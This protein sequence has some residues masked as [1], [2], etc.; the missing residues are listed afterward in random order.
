MLAPKLRF[1]GFKGE[2][3]VVKL[4]DIAHFSKGA[5]V[6]KSDIDLSGSREA[7]RYGEL[8]TIYGEVVGDVHSKIIPSERDVLSED[9]DVLIPSSGETAID[10]STA[11]YVGKNGVAV[12]GD[13][14]IIRTNESGRFLSY[15]LNHGKKLDVARLAQGVSVV[16]LYASELKGLQIEVPAK[17]E[18]EKI[19]DFLMAVDERIELQS[20]KVE[21]LKTYKRG[22]IQKIFSRQ[23]RF[24]QPNGTTF[25][26][27]EIV[28]LGGVA[29]V[30]KGVQLNRDSME[31]KGFPVING[32]VEPSGYTSSYN[33]EK[34]N[35][36]V[37]EGG[38]SCGFVNYIKERFWS[39]GHCYVVCENEHI[40]KMFLFHI[41]KYRQLDIMKLR[42]GSGLPNIQKKDFENMRLNIPVSAEEQQ[43]IATLLSQIDEKITLE[44]KKLEGLKKFKKSLLQRMF[45]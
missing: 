9:N 22:L 7:I 15:L 5:G 6:S 1:P 14:N 31:Q 24:I 39:G 45:V 41:L 38:N 33:T 12:G 32:G 40:N 21:K 19:A 43:K 10:I 29:L 26:E 2:W 37:S 35:I 20:R 18:Q 36:T 11:T 8:Y 3:R 27:W 28:K 42:V 16:H 4:G 30:K 23:V 13:L 17:E 34:D 44:T 25:P